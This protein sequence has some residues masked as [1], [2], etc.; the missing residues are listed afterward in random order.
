[1]ISLKESIISSTKTGVYQAIKDWCDKNIVSLYDINSN[2]EIECHKEFFNM[3]FD[4]V[5]FEH[6]PSYIKFGKIS[7]VLYAKDLYLAYSKGYLK[8]EQLPKFVNHLYATGNGF[9]G[10]D[11]DVPIKI[12]ES[13]CIHGAN[14]DMKQIKHLE[15]ECENTQTVVFENTQIN[16]SDLANLKIIGNVRKL[17]IINTPASKDILKKLTKLQKTTKDPYAIDLECDKIFA[18]MPGVRFIL[19][20]SRKQIEHNPKNNRWYFF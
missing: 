6:I 14:S 5:D 8:K 18:T 2:N 4:D 10:I 16:V 9:N 7:R 20:S 13:F 15:L 3:M 11:M 12:G 19:L 1:M 17:D